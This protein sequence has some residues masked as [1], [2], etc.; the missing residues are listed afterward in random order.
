MEPWEMDWTGVKVDATTPGSAATPGVLQK[1]E[2]Y[3]TSLRDQAQA[4]TD[5]QRQTRDA[6]RTIDSLKVTGAAPS[7][8]RRLLGW[9][10][11][12]E[13][14]A[15]D[16]QYLDALASGI[17]LDKQIAQKG[18]QTEADAARLALSQLGSDKVYDTN[19]RLVSDAMLNSRMSQHKLDHYSKW[20]TKYGSFGAPNEKGLNA[21][22][23]WRM[24][25]ERAH[26]LAAKAKWGKKAKVPNSPMKKPLLP[27][28]WSVEVVE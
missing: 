20:Q 22:Q 11:S 27:K 24:K 13:K 2:G 17:V 16:Q 23:V 18:P 15:A 3:L 1:Q 8:P 14:E 7:G 4:G 6:A 5:L 9:L 10:G 12:N 25:S 28:G 21:D 19:K 26:E